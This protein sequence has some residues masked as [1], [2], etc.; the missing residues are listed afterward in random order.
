VLDIL[1]RAIEAPV[2][3][4]GLRTAPT[5]VA[6]MVIIGVIIPMRHIFWQT[7]SPGIEDLHDQAVD[8][9]GLPFAVVAQGNRPV[10]PIGFGLF[11]DAC[12]ACIPTVGYRTDLPQ[13]DT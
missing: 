8:I 13:L 5:K 7:G 1:G 11:E 3:R 4:V 9:L 6:N 10:P 12:F 2:P